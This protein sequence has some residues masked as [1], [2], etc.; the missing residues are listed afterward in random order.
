[1]LCVVKR[2]AMGR[3]M[4]I[5]PSKGRAMGACYGAVLWPQYPVLYIPIALCA[6]RACYARVGRMSGTGIL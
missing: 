5:S 4:A 2:S 3:A 1:M 6:M